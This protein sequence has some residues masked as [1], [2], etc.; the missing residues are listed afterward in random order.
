M[1][2][3]C[4]AVM[5]LFTA[6]VVVSIVFLVSAV[7]SAC[8]GQRERKRC[9]VASS[10]LSVGCC[11]SQTMLIPRGLCRL[12]VKLARRS[13]RRAWWRGRSWT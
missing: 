11:E 6:L 5:S 3:A 7:G 2:R 4:V 9:V 13:A 10:A 1:S 8:A 12:S